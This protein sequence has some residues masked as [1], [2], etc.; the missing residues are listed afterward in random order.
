[1]SMLTRYRWWFATAA[2]LVAF[3]LFTA[4]F[5]QP[6]TTAVLAATL[7]Q[8]TP[9]VLGALCGIL[10]ERS[11]VINIGIEGQMLMSAFAGFVVASS[12][13]DLLLGVAAGIGCGMLMGA[14]LAFL[15]VCLL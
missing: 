11:G 4:E 15:S 2:F 9:L 12:T 8:S 5:Q 3:T 1:M 10:C 13:G 7:R 14:F 6:Q